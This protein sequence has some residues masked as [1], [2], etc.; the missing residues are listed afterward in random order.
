M[1]EASRLTVLAERFQDWVWQ[2]PAADVR[3]REGQLREDCAGGGVSLKEVVGDQSDEALALAVGKKFCFREAF[4]ELFIN[5]YERLLRRWLIQ[6]ERQYHRD[7]HREL[8][9]AQELILA[10]FQRPQK[11]DNY[12]PNRPFASWIKVAA[13]NLWIAKVVRPRAPQPTDRLPESA[14]GI[15]PEEE[16]LARELNSRIDG[17][18]A[19]LPPDWR[20]VMQLTME[21]LS[22]GDV[23]GQLGWPLPVVYR[24]LHKARKRLVEKLS[25]S[26][27]PSHRGRPRQARPEIPEPPS[28]DE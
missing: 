19:E 12:D 8:D 14:V 2:L 24:L 11:L 20:Q 5:R 4:E 16:L 27:P 6:W 15:T 22:P 25:L 23:A 1:N 18:L 10:F 7:Y 13:R 21:G 3:E 26:L 9:L 28:S 17:A